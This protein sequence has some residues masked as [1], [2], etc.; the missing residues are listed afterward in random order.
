M[1]N[2][3]LNEERRKKYAQTFISRSNLKH[4]NIYNYEKAIY[5]NRRKKVEIVCEKH[6]SFW[7]LPQAHESGE[8]CP[9]CNNRAKNT[10]IIVEEFKAVHGDRYDYSDVE[11]TKA[12][13]PVIIKCKIHG[14]F[15]QAPSEHKRGKGCMKCCYKQRSDRIKQ[16]SLANVK[17]RVRPIPLNKDHI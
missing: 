17:Q 11:Y 9:Y 8:G 4:G 7:K 16:T 3:G 6:G 12:I 15:E 10:E 2:N 13:L 1:P 14:A 5:I